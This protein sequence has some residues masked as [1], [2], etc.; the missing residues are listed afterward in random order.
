MQRRH[1]QDEQK[2]SSAF[3][4]WIGHVFVVTCFFEVYRFKRAKFFGKL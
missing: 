4:A 2:A 1:L 3:A